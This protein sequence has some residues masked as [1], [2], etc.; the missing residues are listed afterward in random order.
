MI[1]VDNL[2]SLSWLQVKTRQGTELLIQSEND[3]VIADWY[4]ALQDTIST[5]VRADTFTKSQNV[6]Q[7][8]A[9]SEPRAHPI[10]VEAIKVSDLG[11]PSSS[12]ILGPAY[13]STA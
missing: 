9:Q 1:G 13:L 4:R 5:H 8:A 12:V 6:W 2:V 3:G 11:A 10:K 7:K